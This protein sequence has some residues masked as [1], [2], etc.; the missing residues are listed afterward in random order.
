MEYVGISWQLAKK[1][2]DDSIIDNKP[3]SDMLQKERRL[4]ELINGAEPEDEAEKQIEEAIE[5]KPADLEKRLRG[6]KVWS[7]N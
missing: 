3:N 4:M 6:N 5:K 2:K 1:K 7:I